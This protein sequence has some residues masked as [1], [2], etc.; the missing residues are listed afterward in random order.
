MHTRSF[1]FAPPARA[2]FTTFT[3]LFLSLAG[4]LAHAEVTVAD[5]W[6]R[7]TVPQQKASGAFMTLTSSTDTRLVAAS[8]T[9]AGVAEIH[10]MKMENNVMKMNAIDSL[11]LPAGKAV[12]L[13][14][15]GYHLML[16]QLPAPLEEGTEIPVSLVFE[17]DAG[18]RTTMDIQ[19][20]VKPLTTPAH[21]DSH[22]HRH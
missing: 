21:G 17:D 10:E 15:G 22:G 8:S 20:P 5:A 13:R 1:P 18:K 11:E 9:A 7:A 19:V 6:A 16:M 2:L 3:A 12:E 14:P 4:T